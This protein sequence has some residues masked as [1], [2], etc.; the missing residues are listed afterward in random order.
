MNYSKP[1]VFVLGDAA[2][3]I[4]GSGRTANE[5]T[6]KTQKGSQTDGELDE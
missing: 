2:L 5:S 1:D 6:N 4:Q 3:L